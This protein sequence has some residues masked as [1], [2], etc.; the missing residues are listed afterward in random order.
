MLFCLFCYYSVKK[1]EN[2]KNIYKFLCNKNLE[3]LYHVVE[4]V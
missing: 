1:R 4:I 2:N 3:K